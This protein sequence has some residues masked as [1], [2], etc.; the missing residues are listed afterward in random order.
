VAFRYKR[1]KPAGD[2]A[3]RRYEWAATGRQQ[4]PDRPQNRPRLVES[5]ATAPPKSC[6]PDSTKHLEKAAILLE[7]LARNHPLP[8]DNK[9]TAFFLTGLFLEAKW[10]GTE[11]SATDVDVPM[12]ELIASGQAAP[13]AILSWLSQR[14]SDADVD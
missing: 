5:S 8:D 2:Y 3:Q 10:H 14:T 11:R 13:D 7:R 4:S 1:A 12:V 9:R 6:L